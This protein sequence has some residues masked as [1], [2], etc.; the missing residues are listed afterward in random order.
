MNA[1]IQRKFS[2][3]NTSDALLALLFE[4]ER[5]LLLAAEHEIAVSL[6]S[7]DFR[8]AYERGEY[9]KPGWEHDAAARA[10][11]H[12]R[13]LTCGLRRALF[14]T[15]SFALA[16]LV[17]A[18]AFGKV[19]PSLPLSAGKVLS[20]FGALL[21]AW[22]TLFELGGYAA[23]Y[24]GQ[25]LHELLHPKFFRVLFLPGVAIASRGQVW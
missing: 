22:A 17:L 11:E 23:T 25:A 20:V 10:S 2:R 4:R 9:P 5:Y 8:A 21:A 1:P 16:G 7:R 6:D 24:M 12:A 3:A 13:H 19:E 15:L 18:A 14:A